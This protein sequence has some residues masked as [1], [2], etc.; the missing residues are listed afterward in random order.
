MF[1]TGAGGDESMMT[2]GTLIAAVVLDMSCGDPRWLPHPV[3]L[4]GRMIIWYERGIRCLVSGRTAEV[5]AGMVLAVGLPAF[6][7]AATYWLLEL[8]L[9]AHEIIGKLTEVLLAYTALAARDLSD[10]AVVVGRALDAQALDEARHAVAHIVGRDTAGLS[11]PDIVRATVE[12]IAE[13]TSDGVI[14][15]LF[16]LVIGGPPLALAYKAVNTLDSMVGHLDEPYRYFGWASARL[17][18]LANWI[19]ARVT[20]CLVI[21]AVGLRFRSVAR[22][23]YAWTVFRRDA[24]KHPS[25]N[26]GRAEAAMAGGLQIQLGGVN[27]YG[28]TSMPRPLLGVADQPLISPRIREAVSIMWLAS[29][30]GA[31]LG[32]C[33]LS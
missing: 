27:Y 9:V 28:G 25:P 33:L 6:W 24:G 16:Y 11:E 8:S 21:A 18:D 17:D 19:P 23:R 14:A 7:Y 12:T 29:F 4:M 10:H 1:V 22:M 31:G 20:A 32:V 2:A 30:L 3:R 26:S 13:S 15:P 5:V